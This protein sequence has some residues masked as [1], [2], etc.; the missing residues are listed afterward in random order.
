MCTFFSDVGFSSIANPRSKQKHILRPKKSKMPSNVWSIVDF[1]NDRRHLYNWT[2]SVLVP[3]LCK[4]RRIVVRGD[5]KC[6]KRLIVQSAT[7]LTKKMGVSHAFVSAFHRVAD[8]PQRDEMVA[9]EL[10]VHSVRTKEDAIKCGDWIMSELAKGNRVVV[11]LDECDYGSGSE[12]CLGALWSKIRD[13]PNITNVLYSATPEEVLFSGECKA[14]SDEFNGLDADETCRL[15]Y[16]PEEAFYRGPKAFLEAGLVTE[17]EPIMD[18]AEGAERLSTQAVA[19]FSAQREAMVTNPRRNVTLLR[20]TSKEK[21]QTIRNFVAALAAGRFPELAGFRIFLDRGDDKFATIPAGAQALTVPWSGEIWWADITERMPVLIIYDQTCTRSTELADHTRIF[22]THD[23]RTSI[24]YNTVAQAQQRVN[25]Y[26]DAPNSTKK[27][28]PE[29]QRIRV[30]GNLK[31]WQFAAEAITYEQYIA[32]DFDKRKITNPAFDEFE[33]FN[34]ASGAVV[35]SHMTKAEAED[36]L[37]KFNIHTRLSARMGGKVVKERVLE[38]DDFYACPNGTATEFDRVKEQVAKEYARRRGVP[39]GDF[40]MQDP[41]RIA[42]QND[43]FINGEYNGVHGNHGAQRWDFEVA[44]LKSD[45]Y[46]TE[47]NK[48]PRRVICYKD[49]VLGLLVSYPLDEHKKTDTVKAKSTSM[50]QRG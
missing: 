9:A 22:A 27:K 39:E 29:F 25:H 16:K 23:Y 30:F 19:L 47:T 34:I 38:Y 21:G 41:F 8:E 15:R 14:I 10:E 46:P 45:P 32:P 3:E 12:Q 1:M 42:R 28:Y 20:I 48:R 13:V 26:V 2:V 43:R 35:Q 37:D 5:V 33:V 36:F 49:G 7:Q 18:G 4:R 44:R 31:T 17:A 11:H 6:G 40:Q 24:T 50:F